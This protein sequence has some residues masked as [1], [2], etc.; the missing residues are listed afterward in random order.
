MTQVS[1][2]FTIEHLKIGN[3]ST[4]AR[5]SECFQRVCLPSPHNARCHLYCS[6]SAQSLECGLC[7]VLEFPPHAHFSAG[8]CLPG[9]RRHRC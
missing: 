9:P 6:F 7:E 3:K 1:Q 5:V 4:I 2:I 8:D